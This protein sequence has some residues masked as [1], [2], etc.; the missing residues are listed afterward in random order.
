MSRLNTRS[1]R[2]G[3]RAGTTVDR[4]LYG[5]AAICDTAP[6][7]SPVRS[8]FTIE[9]SRLIRA[10]FEQAVRDPEEMSARFYRQ[11]FTLDPAL[12]GL[13]HGDMREQGRKLMSTLALIVRSIDQLELLLPAVRELGIRHANYRVE[14]RHY[15]TV[16]DAL[17]WTLA[18]SA[19]ASFT[20]PARAAWSKAYHLLTQTMIAAAREATARPAARG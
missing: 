12:R 15:A 17:L 10:S 4:P 8:H 19:G 16:A 6:M 7:P 5:V 11:L 13:F 18:E 1:R 20:P 9:E 2:R 3:K 14:E